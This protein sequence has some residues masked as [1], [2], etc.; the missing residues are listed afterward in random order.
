LNSMCTRDP[1]NRVIL[2]VL[3]ELEAADP[4]IRTIQWESIATIKEAYLISMEDPILMFK[5]RQ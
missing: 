1:R 3:V 5:D 2:E 4:L